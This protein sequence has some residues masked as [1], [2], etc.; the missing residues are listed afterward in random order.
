MRLE[1]AIKPTPS[2]GNDP[3]RLQKRFRRRGDRASSWV[4]VVPGTPSKGEAIR[5]AK[6]DGS[7]ALRWVQSIVA[8]A[9]ERRDG[10]SVVAVSNSPVPAESAP[11][12]EAAPAPKPPPMLKQRNPR[13]CE[14]CEGPCRP[15]AGVC[16]GCKRGARTADDGVTLRPGPEPEDVF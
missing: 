8:P 7:T 2:R 9:H 15:G 5:V 10:Q 1:S 11:T 13:A 4:A 6:K 12:K 3:K 16:D 14:E